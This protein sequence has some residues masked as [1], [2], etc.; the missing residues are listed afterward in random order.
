L[1]IAGQR[2]EGKAWKEA[3][4]RL[5][6]QIEGQKRQF[7]PVVEAKIFDLS[8]P[9]DTPTVLPVVA[10]NTAAITTIV[11]GDAV[12]PLEE[13]AARHPAVARG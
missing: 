8:K 10:V 12:T 7:L 9:D 3:H 4:R 1:F 2:I 5:L 11:P 6:E 13:K